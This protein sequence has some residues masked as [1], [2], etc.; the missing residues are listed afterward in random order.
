M[1]DRLR[2]LFRRGPEPP[3]RR[4]LEA[5]LPSHRWHALRKGDPQTAEFHAPEAARRAGLVVLN[6][7][8]GSAI[9]RAFET[10]LI[11]NGIVPRP[12]HP[13]EVWRDSL[14]KRFDDWSAHCDAD[15]LG[16]FYSLQRQAVRSLA[17]SGEAFLILSTDPQP[18][19]H[20]LRLRLIPPGWVPQSYALDLA[21]GVR[22][23][24]GIEFDALGRRTAYYVLNPEAPTAVPVRLP[25]IQV[26]HLFEPILPGQRRGITWLAPALQAINDLSEASAGLQTTIKTAAMFSAFVTTA[27]DPSD[28]MR[29]EEERF[30]AL[31]PGTLQY[32]HPGET[33][34]FAEP[35][36]VTE[37]YS[38]F[39]YRELCNIAASLGLTYESISADTSRSNYS[40]SRLAANNARRRSEALQ[41][42]VI[43]PQFLAPLWRRWVEIAIALGQIP[44]GD[45]AQNRAD[46]LRCAWHPPAWPAVDPAK[47]MTATV[48]ALSAGLKSRTQAAAELGLDIET[49]DREIAADAARAARLGLAFGPTPVTQPSED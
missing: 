49:L 4:A 12:G 16:D 29:T 28:F 22:V 25:A 31:E 6:S 2:N 42:G 8:L 1:L 5:G 41:F 37:V 38:E 33:I 44:G 43:I 15:G 48:A 11:G 10:T 32:L 17:I 45:L 19:D 36:R 23:R 34:S 13:S 39:Y 26:L 3:Q 18:T 35:P 14:A 46:F 20:P 47:E 24:Q 7:P 21:D 27:S 40:S 30:A 9:A